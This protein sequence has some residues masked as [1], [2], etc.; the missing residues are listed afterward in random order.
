MQ[1]FK[2]QTDC[3]IKWSPKFST[4]HDHCFSSDQ[5][6]KTHFFLK[7]TYTSIKK[8]YT[9]NFELLIDS[10]ISKPHKNKHVLQ[11][12]VSFVGKNVHQSDRLSTTSDNNKHDF[13]C[14]W[15]VKCLN[16]L[17]RSERHYLSLE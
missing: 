15:E 10:K 4:I 5:T 14:T 8:T 17:L 16:K 11:E 9:L 6:I 1:S 12:F 13:L 7:K 2:L 3:C